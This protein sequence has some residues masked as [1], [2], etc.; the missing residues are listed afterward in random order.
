MAGRVSDSE[1]TRKRISQIGGEVREVRKEILRESE[2]RG[3]RTDYVRLPVG[4]AEAHFLFSKSAVLVSRKV[5]ISERL[6][7]KGRSVDAPVC[8]FDPWSL[9]Q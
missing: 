1:K 5:S 2:K 3:A 7:R 4:A 8:K 6:E 9:K